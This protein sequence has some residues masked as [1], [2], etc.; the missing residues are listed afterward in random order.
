MSSGPKGP[1]QNSIA[2]CSV[3]GRVEEI[4]ELP[5]RAE[6]CCWECS[7]DVATAIL[8][9]TEI[10]AAISADKSIEALV[11]EF[12]EISGRMLKRSQSAE[13]GSV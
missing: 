7:A 3:C 10:D 13:M 9:R 1:E 8:L 5:G 6:R 4:F 2:H 12:T 11:A